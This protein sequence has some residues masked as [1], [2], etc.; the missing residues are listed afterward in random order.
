MG[1]LFF[2]C[3]TTGREVSTGLYV[4]PTTYHSLPNGFSQIKCPDCNQTHSFSDIQPR[5]ATEDDELSL[6]RKSP[7]RGGA[8]CGKE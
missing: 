7:A 5:L 2:V 4:D 3:P 8:E 6:I 1:T